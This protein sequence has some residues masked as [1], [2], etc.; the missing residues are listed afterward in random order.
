MAIR[1]PDGAKKG[2]LQKFRQNVNLGEDAAPEE[3]SS[4][5]PQSH[6]PPYNKHIDALQKILD[7]LYEKLHHIYKVNR[8][9]ARYSL[10]AT[11]TNRPTNRALNKP[12]GPGPN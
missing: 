6:Q 2:N 8:C 7:L 1:A 5:R 3:R 11:T 4:H 10:R 12:A 9:L